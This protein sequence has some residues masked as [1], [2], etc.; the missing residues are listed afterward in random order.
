MPCASVCGSP[1]IEVMTLMQ[2]EENGRGTHP[3]DLPAPPEGKAGW[4]WGGEPP[5]AV[6]W[7][8]GG[9]RP[10]RITVVTPSYNQGKF[11]EQTIRS[12]LLQGYPDL[13]YMVIDGGSTDGSVDVIRRYQHLLSY[14]VSEKDGG[15]AHAINKGFDRASGEIFAYINS[16][17]FYLPGALRAVAEHFRR[18]PASTWVCGEMIFVDGGGRTVSSPQTIIPQSAGQCLSRRY[19]AQQQAM[20][21]RREA[22]G[23]GF[24]ERWR[25]CFDF[26]LFVRLLLAGHGCEHLPLRLAAMR[27]HPD[28]KTVGEARRF[29]DE[30]FRMSK[31]YFGRITP[32]E[33]RSCTHTHLLKQSYEAGDGREAVRYLV[34]ALFTYPEC[35]KSRWFW[36]CLRR[37]LRI[38]VTR[39][40]APTAV[41]PECTG[42]SF[43]ALA[44]REGSN[45]ERPGHPGGQ[46]FKVY[47]PPSSLAGEPRQRGFRLPAVL[48]RRF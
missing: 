47:C 3:R 28:S 26:E 23:G 45:L 14:W 20:F 11:L 30:V 6:A 24:E 35:V 4:P 42:S 17:D 9:S 16:D 21:W 8:F 15:Q 36:G 25:Y 43:E 40:K 39:T 7:P 41:E 13:E 33:R 10:P 27:L 34:R 38:G 22:L 31:G 12:V 1:L 5:P 2:A 29:E 18:S 46:G 44:D 32:S 37:V 19:F 48:T